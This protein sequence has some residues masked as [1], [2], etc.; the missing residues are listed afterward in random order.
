MLRCDVARARSVAG[1]GEVESAR[2]AA[3]S[4]HEDVQNKTNAKEPIANES[5]RRMD[6]LEIITPQQAMQSGNCRAER[7]GDCPPRSERSYNAKWFAA[8]AARAGT[9]MSVAV[10]MSHRMVRA[11]AFVV[12]RHRRRFFGDGNRCQHANDV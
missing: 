9:G 7:G 11:R 10:A 12:E 8:L 4:K 2:G 3:V 1:S 5:M 6:G